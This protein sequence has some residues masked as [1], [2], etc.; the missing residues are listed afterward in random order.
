MKKTKVVV[1]GG[2][3]AGLYAAIYLDKTLARRGEVELTVIDRENFT[4]FTP[5]LHEVAAGDLHPTD[6]VNPIRRILRHARF[7]EA[8]LQAI[9][10]SARCVRCAGGVTR[11]AMEFGF[12]HLLVALGSE[13][14]FFELPGVS[15]WAV[16][17]KTL[18]D[19]TLL[20]NR[21]LALLEEA[22][23]YADPA[24][25]RMLLTFVTAGGGFS[26]VETTGAINDLV[27]EAVGSYPELSEELIRVI[28]AHPGKVLLPELGEKLGRYAEYKLGER[29]VEVL[30]GVRVAGYD[31]S[32]VSFADGKSIPAATLIW[33]AG[34]KPSPAIDALP[35]R[36]E[37]GRLAVNEFLAV[38]E[39]PGLWAVGDCAAVPDLK[40][41]K[42]EP[43]TAQHGLREGRIAAKNIEAAILGRPM[44][45]FT[46]TT[47]GQMATIGHHSGVAMIFGVKF[48]G[49]LAWLMWRSIYLMKLPR[50]PKKLRVVTGWM[51]DLLFSRDLEQMITLRDIEA[52]AQL[53]GRIHTANARRKAA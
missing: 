8:E 11:L 20:R 14:N 28:I 15:E 3:F 37:H 13:T 6:I 27:R 1:L 26:G 25:R 7:V 33:T 47:L 34:V 23:L 10:L 24:M 46:F 32:I 36:K 5:M 22:S 29:K 19:A 43:P 48:S 2:G 18:S 50:L 52:M 41:G 17:M 42:I 4:L 21:V 45:P 53:A 39:C 44:R 30:K 40:T 31:G 49:F 51:H 35:C 38:P 16:T 12:D 9:D